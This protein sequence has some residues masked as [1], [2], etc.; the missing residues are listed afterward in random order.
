MASIKKYKNTSKTKLKK[1]NIKNYS[2]AK[3]GYVQNQRIC[4]G[5][6]KEDCIDG[7]GN[8]QYIDGAKRKYCKRVSKC[9][10]GCQAPCQKIM[11]NNNA[12]CIPP[13]K[14]GK[15]QNIEDVKEILSELIVEGSSASNENAQVQEAVIHSS[16]VISDNH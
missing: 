14:D 3:G 6:A 5:R 7:T 13:D 8:C 15:P 12:Y 4:K 9:K 11:Y 16:E 1:S 10:K 2:I